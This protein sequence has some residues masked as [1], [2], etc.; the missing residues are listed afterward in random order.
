MSVHSV[1]ATHWK[2]MV[3]YTVYPDTLLQQGFSVSLD[4]LC[5]MFCVGK[6]KELLE[7]LCVPLSS[8]A[9]VQSS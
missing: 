2:Q 6:Y 3:I 1:H 5:Q 4:Q 9:D 7:D 8:P